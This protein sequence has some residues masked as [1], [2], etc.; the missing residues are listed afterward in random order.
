[1]AV[2]EASP[3]VCI[4]YKALRNIEKGEMESEKLK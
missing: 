4:L 2:V 1:M 3:D